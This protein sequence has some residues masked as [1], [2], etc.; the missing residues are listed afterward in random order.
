ME[1]LDPTFLEDFL[2]GFLDKEGA[3]GGSLLTRRAFEGWSPSLK[4]VYDQDLTK[5]VASKGQLS[6]L[7][8]G[9]T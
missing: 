2:N 6:F 5:R 7:L 4:R 3:V 8:M 9:L 1:S